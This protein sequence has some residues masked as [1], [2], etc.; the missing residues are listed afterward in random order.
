MAA[1]VFLSFHLICDCC[2]A[3]IVSCFII[4]WWRTLKISIPQGDKT[5]H[6]DT[7]QT[8]ANQSTP[9]FQWFKS[10]SIHDE[11]FKIHIGLTNFKKAGYITINTRRLWEGLPFQF[12]TLLNCC[13]QYFPFLNLLCRPVNCKCIDNTNYIVFHARI[14]RWI[15]RPAKPRLN[16]ISKFH[17][18]KNKLIRCRYPE[19]SS[20]IIPGITI[21]RAGIITRFLTSFRRYH[22]CPSKLNIC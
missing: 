19:P 8:V 2:R 7:T 6:V 15:F 14:V 12:Q 5:L 9:T 10:F 22:K 1:D 16:L 20:H 21:Y 4:T 3:R 18:C 13:F 17:K 11:Y